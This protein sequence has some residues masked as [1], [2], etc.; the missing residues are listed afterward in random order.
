M[1]ITFWHL[2]VNSVKIDKK[3]N[4]FRLYPPIFIFLLLRNEFFYFQVYSW[5]H[6]K[7]A[8]YIVVVV[9][10]IVQ[11]QGSIWLRQSSLMPP[12]VKLAY[13]RLDLLA[14]DQ[15]TLCRNFRQLSSFGEWM[16]SVCATIFNL[17]IYGEYVEKRSACL[18]VLLWHKS[19]S[20]WLE[21][22]ILTEKIGYNGM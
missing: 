7:S 10:Q 12:G 17:S 11:S 4:Y 1:N 16:C 6:L 19:C 13:H 18:F 22:I 20:F 21:N 8:P 15:F 5:Q 3:N 9:V 14:H 2:R